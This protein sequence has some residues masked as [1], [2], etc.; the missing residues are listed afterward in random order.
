MASFGENVAPS[1][2]PFKLGAVNSVTPVVGLAATVGCTTALPFV[3][4]TPNA[5]AA[6]KPSTQ[7]ATSA[8][9]PR[10]TRTT[11]DV[12]AARFR[13]TEAGAQASESW[14]PTAAVLS[15]R[16]TTVGECSGGLGADNGSAAVVRKAVR[17]QVGRH[18]TRDRHLQ[19]AR[20]L[21]GRL[22]TLIAVFGHRLEHD[23]LNRLGHRAIDLRN[24][25]AAR[26]PRVPITPPPESSEQRVPS[27]S[28]SGI[29]RRRAS[30][31]RCDEST[32]SPCACSGDMYSGV[33][34]IMPVLVS[35]LS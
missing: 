20:Q 19:V 33:P 26:R 7:S 28:A 17:L 24:R 4:N 30:R 5:A 6:K 9:A 10:P 2:G 25:A 13:S 3:L 23:R 34:T 8:A 22:V 32:S 31:C 21:T 12:P 27:P 1:A 14:G 11:G 16:R 35:L 15:V 29:A 18:L